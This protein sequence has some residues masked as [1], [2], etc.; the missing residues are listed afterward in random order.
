MSNVKKWA[1][2]IG[3]GVFYALAAIGIYTEAGIITMLYMTFVTLAVAI[4]AKTLHTVATHVREVY[5][6]LAYAIPIVEEEQE[7]KDRQPHLLTSD[8]ETDKDVH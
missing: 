4:N 5:G 1:I 2:R 6:L 3:Y 8:L 7:G